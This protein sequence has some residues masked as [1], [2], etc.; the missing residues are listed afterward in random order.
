MAISVFTGKPGNGKTLT[1]MHFLTEDL[2]RTERHIVTNIPINKPELAEYLERESDKRK[3]RCPKINQRLTVIGTEEAL[4][5]WRFRSNNYVLPKWDGLGNDGKSLSEED[6]LIQSKS[7]F[8]Q[9]GEN[10]AAAPVSYYISEAH[11]YYNAK[12]FQKISVIAELYVTHHRHLHDEV[13]FDTQ[14]PKQL[15]VALRELTEEWHVLRNDYNRNIGFVKMIPRIRMSSYYELPSSTGKPFAKRNIFISEN[16]V[17]SCYQST[18][19]LG[20]IERAQDTET[21]KTKKG[22]PL[23]FFVSGVSLLVIGLFCS[24]FFVPK[25][26]LGLILGEDENKQPPLHLPTSAGTQAVTPSAQSASLV[27]PS[28]P[29]SQNEETEVLTLKTFSYWGFG[30]V[31]SFRGTLSNGLVI[32]ENS[33]GVEA[34][35]PKT[36]QIRYNGKFVSYQREEISDTKTK[37]K[38]S[39]G[40]LSSF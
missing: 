9:I 8:A 1:M 2:L 13:Y 28:P 39:L 34:I 11:R 38:P 36:Q 20:A 25:L 21:K 40:L 32:T 19:A 14:F 33:E 37:A 6:L 29:E 10:D 30:G 16:G 26:A 31:S 18:G 27:A 22:I 12:R 17:A 4:F 5:F 3:I 24:V 15:S 35:N 23:R 7:Y